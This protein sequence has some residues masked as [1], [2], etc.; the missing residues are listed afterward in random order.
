MGT[1]AHDVYLG[2]SGRKISKK[3]GESKGGRVHAR[4]LILSKCRYLTDSD[5]PIVLKVGDTGL[6]AQAR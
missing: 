5:E 4:P 1:K 3:L 6:K 2:H